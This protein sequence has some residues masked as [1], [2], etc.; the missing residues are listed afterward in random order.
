[1][2]DT[3]L[4]SKHWKTASVDR[5]CDVYNSSFPIQV[6]ANPV[7]QVSVS[8]PH[9]STRPE[10]AP[11]ADAVKTEARRNKAV[12]STSLGF[13]KEKLRETW[14]RCACSESRFRFG[15]AGS[16]RLRPYMCSRRCLAGSRQL[17]HRAK[18]EQQFAKPTTH[19]S[20]SRV[21]CTRPEPTGPGGY[22]HTD[23]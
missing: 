3:D 10:T 18:H 16:H 11:E 23:A 21:P 7:R 15:L 2:T 9:P 22:G 1:M 14:A 12:F 17:L 13:G 8:P 6:D 5:C 19:A 20:K 4:R